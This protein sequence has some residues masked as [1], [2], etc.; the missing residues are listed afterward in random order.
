MRRV[1][2]E[3]TTATTQIIRTIT[4]HRRFLPEEGQGIQQRLMTEF[5]LFSPDDSV[6]LEQ[7]RNSLVAVV[8]ELEGL[9]REEGLF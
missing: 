1:E 9:S 7:C 3:S 2:E 6:V 5:L 8:G 4:L